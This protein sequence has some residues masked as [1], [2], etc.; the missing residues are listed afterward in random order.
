MLKKMP[1]PG[2]PIDIDITG[3]SITNANKSLNIGTDSKLFLDVP[4]GT[5]RSCLMIKTRDE[6][7]CDTVL[8]RSSVDG[9]S[10]PKDHFFYY[11]S[12]LWGEGWDIMTTVIF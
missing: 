2:I 6:K 11:P 5:R 8:L 7:S 9:L 10:S 1:Y 3:E 4:F 12:P